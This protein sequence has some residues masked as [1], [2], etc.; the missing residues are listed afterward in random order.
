VSAVLIT[1]AIT[2]LALGYNFLAAV[3]IRE[4]AA[5]KRFRAAN[6]DLMLGVLALAFLW[7]FTQIGWWT[8]IPELLGGWVGTFYGT[9]YKLRSAREPEVLD[10]DGPDGCGDDLAADWLGSERVGGERLADPLAH[11]G[12]QL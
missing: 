7:S 6:V 8:A 1:A 9:G 12:Q 5:G 3:G 4:V 11:A 10:L 2:G